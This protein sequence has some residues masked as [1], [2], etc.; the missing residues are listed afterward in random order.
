MT[1]LVFR[2]LDQHVVGGLA[3]DPAIVDDRGSMSFAQLLHESASVAGAISQ[4]GVTAGTDVAIDLPTGRERVI[5]VL[6]CARLGAV[7]DS[8]ATG[9][10]LTGQPPVFHTPETEATWDL[11]IHAGRNEPAP[12]P[13][14]DPDGYEEFLLGAYADVFAPLIAGRTI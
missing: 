5:A 12:A 1:S 14:A 4:L 6:A 13:P 7:P 3:D 8:S 10:R 2:A 9:Y 11:L